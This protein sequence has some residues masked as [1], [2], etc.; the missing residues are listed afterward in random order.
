MHA[1][2]LLLSQRN[3][4][5]PQADYFVIVLVVVMVVMMEMVVMVMVV[6]R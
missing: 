4:N 2:H 5:K 1:C 3:F 6:L